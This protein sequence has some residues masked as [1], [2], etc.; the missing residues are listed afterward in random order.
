MAWQGFIAPR[1]GTK[2]P[3]AL[4]QRALAMYERVLGINHPHTASTLYD[5][6]SLY[7]A[8]GEREE[9]ERI[10]QHFLNL[11]EMQVEPSNPATIEVWEKID[12][13]LRGT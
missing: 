1:E 11:Y 13:L 8:Q 7:L 4:F 3:E 9:A 10:Y 6:I 5:L 2:R 12:H